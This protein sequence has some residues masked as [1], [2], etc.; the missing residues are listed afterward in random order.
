M[1]MSSDNGKANGHWFDT[2]WGLP[3]TKWRLCYVNL[4]ER[5]ND[6]GPP[7]AITSFISIVNNQ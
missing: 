1:I 3:A 5:S 2:R 7:P 6:R 4:I